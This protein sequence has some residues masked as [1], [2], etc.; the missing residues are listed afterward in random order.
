[1][2]SRAN[3]GKARAKGKKGAIQDL[4]VRKGEGTQGGGRMTVNVNRFDPYK[5]FRF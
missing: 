1:M 2:R 3:K 5:N 4:K